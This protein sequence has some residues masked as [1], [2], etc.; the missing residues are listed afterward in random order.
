MGQ[1]PGGPWDFPVSFLLSTAGHVC[2][3]YSS[4]LAE[5]VHE[6]TE[7]SIWLEVFL[8]LCLAQSPPVVG[9]E[10]HRDYKLVIWISLFSCL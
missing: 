2:V 8:P 3:L 1:T 5:S 9:G 7:H 4:W 10:S 6:A